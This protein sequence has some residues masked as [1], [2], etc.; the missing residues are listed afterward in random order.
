M[1]INSISKDDLDHLRQLRTDQESLAGPE[2]FADAYQTVAIANAA[3]PGKGTML[4][5]LY[6][7]CKQN[8]EAGEIAE[9]AGKF[10]RDDAFSHRS[11]YSPE[12]DRPNM[13]FEFGIMNNERRE[14][15]IKEIGDNLW[16]LAAL[17]QELNTTLSEAML[18][19]IGKLASR[20]ERGT[21]QGEGDQR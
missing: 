21:L 2:N 13:T 12:A 3:Y 17:C 18:E 20:T 10:L 19:N 6:L 16:Y 14:L 11:V 5:L 9:H 15:I 4:G 7:A 8:G 1:V